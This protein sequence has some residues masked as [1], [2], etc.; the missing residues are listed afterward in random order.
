M[1]TNLDSRVVHEIVDVLP[2]SQ[3]A[4]YK[5]LYSGDP[6][7]IYTLMSDGT[8]SKVSVGVGTLIP[9]IGIEGYGESI[10]IYKKAETISEC[11]TAFFGDGNDMDVMFAIIWNDRLVVFRGDGDNY[12]MVVIL[13]GGESLKTA[14]VVANPVAAV[15]DESLNLY[16]ATDKGVLKL[17]YSD[18]TNIVTSYKPAEGS[19]PFDK[20]THMACFGNKLFITQNE[21]NDFKFGIFDGL[22]WSDLTSKFYSD[23]KIDNKS[24]IDAVV[25]DM[26]T[27][28]DGTV[29]ISISGF[30]ASS[31]LIAYNGETFFIKSVATGIT[32]MKKILKVGDVI[33]S[34]K[35]DNSLK[36]WNYKTLEVIFSGYTAILGFAREGN[37]I[38]IYKANHIYKTKAGNITIEEDTDVLAK[39]AAIIT[40]DVTLKHIAAS[41]GKRIY[42]N[43]NG[44]HFIIKGEFLLQWSE[45]SK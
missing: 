23:T 24:L 40:L 15:V 19:L 4:G 3:V 38:M 26:I 6:G 30:D 27:D 10:S 34:I 2:T 41:A 13:P 18:P 14:A 43:E 33:Y 22:Q 5:C 12:D 44:T 25:Y 45:F 32:Y 28:D 17:R 9:I 20:I 37:D 7:V 16:V 42:L 31:K 39:L 29:L 36:V 35:D 8:W 21:T 1:I 11:K